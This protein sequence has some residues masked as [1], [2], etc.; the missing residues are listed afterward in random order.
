ML[1]EGWGSSWG[2][3]EGMGTSSSGGAATSSTSSGGATWGDNTS[4]EAEGSEVEAAEGNKD[5][6]ANVASADKDV[7]VTASAASSWGRCWS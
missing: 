4:K 3:G 1:Q 7:S 5:S 2:M 6:G